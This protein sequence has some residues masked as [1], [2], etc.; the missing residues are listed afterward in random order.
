MSNIDANDVVKCIDDSVLPE[1]LSLFYYWPRKGEHYVV[2]DVLIG[3]HH[4]KKEGSVRLL[5]VGLV[6][7]SPNGKPSCERGYD[8]RRFVKLDELKKPETEH[9]EHYL[10]AMV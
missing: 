3:V 10:P 9:H 2:R 4:P 1:I 8:A 7:P 5:L 6:N